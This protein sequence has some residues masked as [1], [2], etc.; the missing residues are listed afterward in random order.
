MGLYSV[1]LAIGQ[2][3]GSFV[4]AR[5]AHQAGL[6]GILVATLV[7]LGIAL[8]PLGRLR[9]FEHV[10]GTAASPLNGKSAA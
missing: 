5:A 1:F 10:V 3:I 2:I 4:G 7:L 6:D 8:I 9:P